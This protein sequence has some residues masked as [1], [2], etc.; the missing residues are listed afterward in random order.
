MDDMADGG[1]GPNLPGKVRPRSSAVHSH[2]EAVKITNPTNAS[3]SDGVICLHCRVTLT[4][5]VTT[6]LKS[7]L[8]SKHPEVF[9]E[10]QRKLR[11]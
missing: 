7:H 8:K 6:N 10:V 9:D 4:S 11:L 3:S 5:K 1:S 2:Y